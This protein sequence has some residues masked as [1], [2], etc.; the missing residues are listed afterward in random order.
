MRKGFFRKGISTAVIR[1]SMGLIV[2]LLILVL[3]YYLLVSTAY[4]VD[5]QQPAGTLRPYVVPEATPTPTPSPT[6]SPTPQED[7]TL[8]PY[9]TPTPTP[10]TPT[11]EPTPTPTPV[12]T[13][14]PAGLLAVPQPRNAGDMPAVSAD[15][16]AALTDS[17]VSTADGYRVMKL[18]GYA[19]YEHPNYNGE[20]S[21]CYL[22]VVQQ[23]TGA[24][25]SYLTTSVEGLT[26][27]EHEGVGQNLADS[28]FRVYIDVSQYSDDVYS[29]GLVLLCAH[30]GYEVQLA[31]RFPDTMN[32]A[33]RS[34]EIIT[35]VRLETSAQPTAAASA[36]PPSTIAPGPETN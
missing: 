5:G 32:F 23:S 29:L 12:P 8:P 36:T 6:P 34:G 26:G 17:Y 1:F 13:S 16:R 4:E 10:A 2:L 28:D 27:I 31:Y 20:N 11:P 22:I 24:I 3:L 14:I 18:E 35:P 21:S 15:V 25:M 33:V 7:V 19:Y 9:A 30:N